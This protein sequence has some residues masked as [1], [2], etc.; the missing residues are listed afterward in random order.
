MCISANNQYK[1]IF[2]EL[3]PGNVLVSL[4]SSSFLFAT[5]RTFVRFG[6]PL[7]MRSSSGSRLWGCRGC[8]GL[9]FF[10][11]QRAELWEVFAVSEIMCFRPQESSSFQQPRHFMRVE[12]FVSNGGGA[13]GSPVTNDSAK[14]DCPYILK[15]PIE[16]LFS[17]LVILGHKTGWWQVQNSSEACWSPYLL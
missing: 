15:L 12:S 17:I 10:K 5:S 8:Q 13:S 3:E 2:G 16:F 7:T 1:C 6:F 11:V 9:R 4:V 14:G